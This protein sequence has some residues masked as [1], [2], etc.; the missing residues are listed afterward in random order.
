MS[1]SF[2]HFSDIYKIGLWSEVDS[3]KVHPDL[4][5]SQSEIKALCQSAKSK[6]TIKTYES[7]FKSFCKWCHRYEFSP[8]PCSSYTLALYLAH[9][10]SE[11]KSESKLNA[12]LFSIS[13]A[14]KQSGFEDPSCSDLI[15]QVK[16]G[17]LRS[18]GKKQTP[19]A[20]LSRNDIENIVTFFGNDECLF[21][22]RFVAM[23]VLS[24]YGFL[25]FS[26]VVRLKRSDITFKED[27]IEIN[28]QSSK[29]DQYSKGD[30]VCI[31]E[32]GTKSCPVQIL[33]NYLICAE[34]PERSDEFLFRNVYYS[35]KLGLH[36]LRKGNHMSYTRAR[37]IFIQKLSMLG[38]DSQKYG[39][40]SFRSGGATAA[41][42]AGVNDRLIKK[43]GRWKT[44]VSKD[45]YI[46]ESDETKKSVT[47]KIGL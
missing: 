37:E 22:K 24:F 40:H 33:R 6:N 28:I 36:R 29:T 12:I 45:K 43:H 42:K 34:I 39:L 21:N 25:R 47:L 1:V 46:H 38:I 14:H 17:I 27:C 2:I 20:P 31:S 35:K 13:Y 16:E 32:S 18:V 8:I 3:I 5:S 41:A 15:K 10:K 19:K 44:D 11:V 30:T 23:A 4:E 9:V 26:E 7:Y